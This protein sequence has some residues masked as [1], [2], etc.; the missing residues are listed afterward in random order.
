VVGVTWIN[1]V[2]FC[3]KLAQ[4]TGRPYR[5]PSEAEWEYA[6]RAGTTTPF[7]FGSTITTEVA[8][9][10]GN[11]TYANSSTGE[12]RNELTSVDYFGIA[13]AYG[14]CDMHGNAYEWCQD[15]WHENY[16][17][18]PTDGSAWSEGGTRNL[19]VVRGGSWSLHPRHCR[20]AFRQGRPRLR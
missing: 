17:H 18:A 5:L 3:D 4:Q 11:F 13:N 10:N 1:A 16:E 14:L 7:Y 8:N 9:Y 6:C 20:S 2:R 19:R 12:Y 15:H